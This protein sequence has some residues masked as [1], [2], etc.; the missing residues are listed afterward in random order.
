MRIKEFGGRFGK[1]NNAATGYGKVAG[2]LALTDG[3]DRIN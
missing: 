2:M 1:T 3:K